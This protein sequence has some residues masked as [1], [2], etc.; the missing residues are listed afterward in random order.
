[1]RKKTAWWKNPRNFTNTKTVDLIEYIYYDVTYISFT[2]AT[3]NEKS[4]ESK[5]LIYNSWV[6]FYIFLNRIGY[7]ISK[8]IFKCYDQK[9][10]GIYSL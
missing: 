9:L 7:E 3:I 8:E 2:D 1:M 4:L 6:Y 10:S 5:T